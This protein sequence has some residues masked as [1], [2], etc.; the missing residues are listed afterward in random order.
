MKMKLDEKLRLYD[1]RLKSL[2]IIKRRIIQIKNYLYIT[3]RKLI[4]NEN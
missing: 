3:I 1:M 2:I 4:Y